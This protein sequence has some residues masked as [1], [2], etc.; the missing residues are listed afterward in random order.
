[1]RFLI[2]AIGSM[3]AGAVIESLRQNYPNCQI[4]GTDIHPKEWLYLS[5]KVDFFYKVPKA[6]NTDFIFSI[7]KICSDHEIDLLL[8]LTDPEVDILSCKKNELEQFSS[9]VTLPGD[10]VVSICRNKLKLAEVFS[11][12]NLI[13]PIETYSISDVTDINLSYPLVA[14]PRKGRSSEGLKYIKSKQELQTLDENYIIQDFIEGEIITVDFVRHRDGQIASLPRKELIRSANGAGLTVEIFQDKR[15]EKV[16]SE[17]AQKLQIFGCMNVEFIYNDGEYY[18]MDINPR[19][20]AG[21]GFSR[22]VGYDFIKN[23]IRVFV[24]KELGPMPKISNTIA[25]KHYKEFV[26]A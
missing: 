9:S 16:V 17:V 3:A 26:T 18:L 7:L 10:E 8:P 23:H 20:S 24:D 6:I 13:N 2:T 22:L 5:D 1:M 11:D 19:F 14:K 25:V 15:I 4:I 12:N 21:I